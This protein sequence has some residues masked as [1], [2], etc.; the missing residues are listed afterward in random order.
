[1]TLENDSYTREI[2]RFWRETEAIY[3]E[4]A[5][6]LGMSDSSFDILY[7]IVRLGEGCTQ[8]DISHEV[9]LGK[10]TLNS[11]IHKLANQ[12]LLEL[13]ASGRNTLIFL[14]EDG[15]ALVK[16]K[17]KPVFEAESQ[18]LEVVG[19]DNVRE[20]LRISKLYRD[21]LRDSLQAVK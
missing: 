5:V 12:G 20:F 4:V 8:K 11:S 14:T 6:R 21:A 18:A 13:K 9:L 3:H 2:D 10:Q 16:E 1:M 15:R 7:A 19:A 17:I